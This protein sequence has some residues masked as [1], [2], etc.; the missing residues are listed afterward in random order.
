V[1]PAVEALRPRELG[2][3]NT[4]IVVFSISD[5]EAVWA[6]LGA[7]LVGAPT[8]RIVHLLSRCI[9]YA[10]LGLTNIDQYIS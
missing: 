1:G 2:V 7:S 3:L 6:R 8:S 10:A 9:M 5:R 4:T